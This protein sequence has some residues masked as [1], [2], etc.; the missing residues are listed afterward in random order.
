MNPNPSTASGPVPLFTHV[1]GYP[2]MGKRREWKF[3]LEAYWKGA[4]DLPALEETGRGLRRENLETQARAGI[5]LLPSGDF[6][7][8]D[9][10]LDISCLTGNVPERFGWKGEG[11]VDADTAFAMAR[12]RSGAE[13]SGESSACGCGGHQTEATACAMRKWFDTNY[14]FIVPEINEHT[15]F[16]LTG[17]APFDAFSE[18]LALGHR[19]KP[20]LIGPVTYLFLAKEQGA[21]PDFDRWS[22]LPA[23]VRV[24]AEIL[25][26]LHALGAEWVQLDEPVF[27]LDLEARHRGYFQESYRALAAAAPDLKLLVAAYFGPAGQNLLTLATLPVRAIHLDL[28][29]GGSDLENVLSILPKG[30]ILSLGVVSGRNIWRSRFAE[31]LPG[32]REAVARLGADRVWLAPSCSL[33][34]VPVSLESERQLAPEV[35][36]WLAFAEEKLEELKTLAR[37]AT[38][39]APEEDAAF[40]E[41]GR[42]HEARAASELLNRP[43]M[44]RRLEAAEAAGLERAQAFGERRN[45]QRGQLNLPLFPTTT[46]G[47]FPQTAE[48]RAWRSQWRKGR[49]SLKDYETLLEN[50]TLRCLRIQESLGLDVLVHGEFERTDMVEYFGAQLDGFAFTEY[51]WVQSYG[52]RCVK[53]PIIFGDVERPRPMTVRW[54]QFARQNTTRPMK[55]MLTGPVTILNWSFVRDDLPRREVCRQIGLAIREEVLDLEA[56]GCRII[57]IDEAALREGLPLRVKDQ[58]AYLQWTV[59]AF[60]LCTAGVKDA[61]QIHTH[62]CYSDFTGILPAIARMD[63]DVI[64]IETSRSAMELLE[65]FS[66]FR[67]PNGIGPGVYDIHSPRVPQREEI[68]LL[69]DKAREVLPDENLWVNPDC[70]LKTRGWPE[71]KAALA[72]MVEVARD[73]RE[74]V[75]AGRSAAAAVM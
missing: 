40:L 70:G 25:W 43:A 19:T 44:R 65:A 26:K 52:S 29:C 71:V 23:L 7:F 61:T 58:A 14:H 36:S 56:A 51:G 18:A 69:L 2:R 33:L 4:T 3:A 16:R 17:S 12:G 5:N 68:V 34:H 8:Y 27:S 50:E 57:Q 74:R 49:L 35:R 9:Q 30:K 39:A 11:K 13:V 73:L 21:K 54:F 42:L 63:A 66:G 32:I 37:L 53:P 46:I 45:I 55:G 24:Y 31:V 67:Y 38:C 62:M 28:T 75:E 48:V 59:D 64:T 41:N 60:R 6:S 1:S 22:L 47:S 20:V 15:D 10:V 72:V